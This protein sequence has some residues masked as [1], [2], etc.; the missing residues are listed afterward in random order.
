M[1]FR[2]SQETMWSGLHRLTERSHAVFDAGGLRLG[3]PLAATH[4][5]ARRLRADADVLT[6]YEDLLEQSIGRRTFDPETATVELSGGLDSANVAASL[7]SRHPA[8]VTAS[9]LL[10]LDDAGQQQQRRREEMILRFGLGDDVTVAMQEHLPLSPGGRRAA[11]LPISPYEDPYDEA[12]ARLL[13]RLR[14]HGVRSVFTG[15][16]GDEMVSLTGAEQPHQAFGVGLEIMP[17][18]GPQTRDALEMAES[19]IAPATVVN[20][21]T[22]IS[23]ACAAPPMLRAGMWPIHPLADPT[24]IRFGEWLPRS[25]REGKRLHRERLL[26]LGCPHDLV[27]PRLPENFAPVMR[28]AIRRH[29]LTYLRRMLAEGS[30]LIDEQFIDPAGL[31]VTI[32]RLSSHTFKPRDTEVYGVIAVEAALRGSSTA[33]PD[34]AA[35]PV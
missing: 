32:D 29:G 17:W 20:E 18:I 14:D 28:L 30:A 12:K 4:S 3:Y 10:I 1:R 19:G 34:P 15:V 9:A 16:G 13:C 23:Q 8:L 33:I 22:L 2:Y 6:A 25:W 26:R 24:L 27:E 21:M 35:A 11:N 7:G 5:T 31:A